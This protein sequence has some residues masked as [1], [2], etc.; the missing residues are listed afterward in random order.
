MSLNVVSIRNKIPQ[1]PIPHQEG[2]ARLNEQ[3]STNR[4]CNPERYSHGFVI[5]PT[6]FDLCRMLFAHLLLLLLCP[7]GR[8][9]SRLLRKTPYL[10]KIAMPRRGAFKGS[11]ANHWRLIPL[12][13]LSASSFVKSIILTVFPLSLLLTRAAS[14][15][16][17]SMRIT[18]SLPR[19][20][21][22]AFDSFSAPS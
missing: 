17:P 21:P 9:R 6:R 4:F 19:Y 1:A 18:M 10:A 3:R 14:I 5:R 2:S 8:L 11:C 15:T 20:F 16:F 13:I 7:V 22:V 12:T